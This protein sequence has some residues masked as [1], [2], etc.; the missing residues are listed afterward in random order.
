MAGFSRRFT[1]SAVALGGLACESEPSGL[2]TLPVVSITV[3]PNA[4]TLPAGASAALTVAV[5]D[6]EG[7]PLEDREV[8]WSSS[9]PAIAEVS[10]TGVV[11]A[12]V[13]GVASIGAYSD[14]SVGFARVVVQMDFRLPVAAGQ[15]L[16]RSEI[17][18]PTT[19]CASGEGVLIRRRAGM[20]ALGDLPLQSR[21]HAVRRQLSGGCRSG[22]RWN[23]R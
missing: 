10:E 6:L 23:R 17:G 8:R 3:T 12:L 2:R 1:L 16:L 11:T 22:G 18:T 4:L 7:R 21:F 14:H 9:S 15:A 19:L 20:L 5:R 13:P